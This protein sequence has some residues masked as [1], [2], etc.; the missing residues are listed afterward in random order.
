MPERVIRS[1]ERLGLSLATAE[2]LTGGLLAAALTGVPGAS[3]VFRGGVVAY[4]TPMKQVLAG[5][6]EDV[7]REFGPVG[8]RTAVELALGVRRVTGADWAV[9]TTG[10]AGPDTQAG[11]PVG[12]VWIGVSGRVESAGAPFE[13]ARR[14]DF[15]GT[16]EQIRA[17]SV[18]AALDEIAAALGQ[19]PRTVETSRNAA[20]RRQPGER[21]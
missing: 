3:K 11:H 19:R 21:E 4:Q 15:T 16:R 8:G 14:F 17:Q 9:S 1:L 5:V 20:G 10:V 12:E 6:P 7:L 13:S 18:A 2:S